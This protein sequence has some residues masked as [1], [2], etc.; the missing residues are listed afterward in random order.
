M[1][2]RKRIREKGKLAL[3]R[4]FKKFNEGDKVAV[5]RN[6]SYDAHFP[7]RLQGQT[8]IIKGKRGRSYVIDIMMGNKKKIFIIEAIHLNKLKQ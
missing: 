3:S 7:E 2:C 6:L 4:Y 1:L 8:G 5:V